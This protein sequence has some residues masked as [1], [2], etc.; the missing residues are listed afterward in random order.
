MSFKFINGWKFPE[1]E[2]R[3]C[4]VDAQGN[5]TYTGLTHINQALNYVKK[6]DLFL[7]VGANVGLISVPLCSKFKKV[8]SIECIPETYECLKYNLEKFTNAV[9]LNFAVSDENGFIKVAIPKSNG[10]MVSSGWAS[11]SHERQNSFEEKVFLDVETKTIDSLNL[12]ALDFLKID[13]EQ[14]EM[15]VIKGAIDTIRKFKPV[16]EFENKRGEN[17]HVL[18]FLENMGYVS[19]PGRKRKSSECILY[20]PN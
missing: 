6:F 2:S 10:E 15:M 12:N 8:I 1:F 17:I 13:V 9:P 14:A 7:D 18:S 5:S 3:L 19:I 20:F 16:I 4:A 11:I